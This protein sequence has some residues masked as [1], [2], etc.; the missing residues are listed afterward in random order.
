[1]VPGRGVTSSNLPVGV[2]LLK[3]G[4]YWKQSRQALA[5][6]S[7]QRGIQIGKM[8][9]FGIYGAY[10]KVGRLKSCQQFINTECRQ[11]R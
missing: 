8:N 9:I 7:A 2:W 5:I 4:P 1:M 6:V 3:L 10:R 11:C